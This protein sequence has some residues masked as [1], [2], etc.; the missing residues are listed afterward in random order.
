MNTLY[1]DSRQNTMD[2][3][4][5][6]N[7]TLF[8]LVLLTCT[9]SLIY[10]LISGDR[11]IDKTS[12]RVTHTY[13]VISEAQQLSSLVESILASQRGYIITGNSNFMKEYEARRNRLAL[14]IERLK[15]LTSDNPLQTKRIE[16]LQRD[17]IDFSGKLEERARLFVSTAKTSPGPLEDVA[18][19]NT[20]KEKI[21]TIN[22]AIL[23]S[24]Y[25][26]LD[27]RIRAV[28]A[29]KAKYFIVLLV[30][31]V[32]ASALLLLFN[33]FLLH[34]QRKR[35]RIEESLRDKEER[36]ALAID[37][38]QAGIFDWNLRTGDVFYSAQFFR[39]LG[40]DRE[41]C[42]GT[43]QEFK[44]FLHPDDSENVW[45]YVENYLQKEISEYS[46]EF[47]LKNSS[48]GWSW[49]NSRAK[50]ICDPAGKPVRMVGAH[51]D[52]SYLKE[53]QERLEEEKQAAESANRAK[54]DFL[55]H[56]SH[57]IR[58]PLT[59]ISGIA[60]IFEKNQDNLNERQ[61]KLVDSLYSSSVALKDLINDVLDFSKIES[62]E[63]ELSEEIFD[64][65]IM[66]EETVSMMSER[67]NEKNIHL[68]FDYRDVLARPF[69]GD[70]L[71]LRQIL[72]NLIGNALKF[73]EKGSVAVTAREETRQDR[74]F[75][76]IDIRD[77]GIGISPE[78]IDI[79]FERFKQA[80]PSVSR[81]YGGTGLGLPISKNLAGLM[82]GMIT[83]QS[84]PGKGSVFSVLLPFR[85]PEDRLNEAASLSLTRRIDDQIRSALKN[86]SRLLI[87]EDYDG[88][89]VVL[90]YLLDDLGYAY[91]LA[92]T[93][94]EAVEFW[95]KTPY[96]IILMDIQMPVMDGFTATTEIRKLEKEG[97]LPRT[98]IIGMTAHALV[99]DKDKC[100]AAGMDAYLP[101]PIVEMDLKMQIL[102][103]LRREKKAA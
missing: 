2:K 9:G 32:V 14:N 69:L 71:R 26:M 95:K 29:Q 96:D 43:T 27:R 28:E 42:I 85:S 13:G 86:G 35:N 21:L 75:L 24:E 82:G 101:K 89:I 74:N 58:T 83:A 25:E 62:G 50:M 48:G 45:R 87:V 94:L 72:I 55:A 68:T 34:I 79:I 65:G 52:I 56:M 31:A 59:A 64:L 39:M 1:R 76:R 18:S 4:F 30:G 54:S 3:I 102:R 53:Q 73:T 78:N 70:K 63:L 16:D 46:Q 6:R 81:K 8:F 49:I 20:L 57:E 77:T 80:D 92:Q 93:G 41:S 99:G 36:F 19:V 61:K 12:D 23:K 88:N 17:F 33:G 98:P 103:Y 10:V 44:D 37:G 15:N 51:T 38:T 11:D 60:E 47:R 67:A 91:D 97:N 100:I 90:T 7:Y 84:E 22:N 66:F 5:L 40:Y